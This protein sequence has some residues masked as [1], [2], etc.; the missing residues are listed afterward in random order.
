VT[1]AEPPSA[2]V[3]RTGYVRAKT[4][5]ARSSRLSGPGAVTERRA[6]DR[7]YRA[8]QAHS[9]TRSAQPVSRLQLRLGRRAGRDQHAQVRAMLRALPRS[10][11]PLRRYRPAADAK[12]SDSGDG[13]KG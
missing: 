1:T 8:A 12:Q 13:W 6:N 9:P 4:P 5:L 2:M 10:G 7:D 11:D 3:D